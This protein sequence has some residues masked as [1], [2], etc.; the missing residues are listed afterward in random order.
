[1]KKVRKKA[2]WEDKVFITLYL[3]VYT[4]SVFKLIYASILKT[5]N[6]SLIEQQIA[7][8][9]A[10]LAAMGKKWKGTSLIAKCLSI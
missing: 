8:L 4:V 9:Q 6:P 10:Q 1:M 5:G 3:M 2:V 7:A